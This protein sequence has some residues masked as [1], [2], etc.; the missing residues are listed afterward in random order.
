[1]LDGGDEVAEIERSARAQAGEQPTGLAQS[2][3]TDLAEPLELAVPSGAVATKSRASTSETPSVAATEA[4]MRSI[5]SG[6][7]ARWARSRS[8]SHEAMPRSAS[9]S[10]ITDCP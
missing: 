2:L 7:K 4:R 8:R 3:A 5:T 6:G 1:V 9:R 10:A